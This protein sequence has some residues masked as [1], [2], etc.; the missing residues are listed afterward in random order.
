MPTPSPL[1]DRCR[2]ATV[3]PVPTPTP[4]PVPATGLKATSSDA[5]SLNVSWNDAND[6]NAT[7]VVQIRATHGSDGFTTV[8]TLAKGT[9]SYQ[10]KGLNANWEY[11]VQVTA[12][13]G[14]AS[15]A[16]AVVTA[17]VSAPVAAP[18]V[19]ANLKT[20]S[21]NDHELDLAWTDAS[22]GTEGYTV[23][24]K[25]THGDAPFFKIAT[26]APG[27]TGFH[28]LDLNPTWEY[29]VRVTGVGEGPDSVPATATAQVG[30]NSGLVWSTNDQSL[31]AA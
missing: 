2:A 22:N 20:M 30:A 13:V 25:A 5:Q 12:V 24:I 18:A 16:P 9:T 23:E 14:D 4:D 11:D 29:D 26:L 6:G 8:A 28:I 21:P 19:P 7:Y 27:V 17:Q 3:T 1:T 15:A 31:Q 10:V